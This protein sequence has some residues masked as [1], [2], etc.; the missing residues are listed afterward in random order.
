MTKTIFPK[1]SDIK[2]A[3][4]IVDAKGKVLGRLASR[5][6][7]FLRGKTKL[8]FTPN[9]DFKDFV[10]VINTKD[11]IVTGDKPLQK[12]LAKHTGYPS[13]LKIK[14]FKQLLEERPERLFKKALQGMMPKTVLSKRILKRVKF[15]AGAEH[16]HL[17]QKPISLDL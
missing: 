12:F 11:V 14:T 5:I 4:Y 7:N 16:G 15:Y 3:Y 17:A 1:K 8:N 9:V 10:A 2:P 6:A 13:G